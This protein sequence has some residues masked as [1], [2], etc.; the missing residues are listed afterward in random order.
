MSKKH[1]SIF[2]TRKT[3][4]SKLQK[5]TMRKILLFDS[6]VKVFLEYL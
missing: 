2:S 6:T 4:Q 1:I 3:Y 5:I